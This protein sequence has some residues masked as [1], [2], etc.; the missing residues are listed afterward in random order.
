[1]ASKAPLFSPLAPKGCRKISIQ[2]HL[3]ADRH[4]SALQ[5]FDDE[6]RRGLG[7]QVQ[8]EPVHQINDSAWRWH[9]GLD[10]ESTAILNDLYQDR[11]VEAERIQRLVS[12]FSLTFAN[13]AEMRV[14][15]YYAHSIAHLFDEPGAAPMKTGPEGPVRSIAVN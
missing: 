9:V 6:L 4:L 13:P 15:A 12:L 10:V 3:V 11:P 1:M 7:V 14:L 5:A 2:R 8:I